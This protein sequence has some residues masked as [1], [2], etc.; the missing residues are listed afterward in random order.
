[1][2]EAPAA[3]DRGIE[4]GRRYRYAVT[5]VD[6]KGNESARSAAVEVVAP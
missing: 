3:S 1:L 6:Q 2:L 5:A 4:T